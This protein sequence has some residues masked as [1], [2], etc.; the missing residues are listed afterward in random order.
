MAWQT[1]DRL[2]GF[3]ALGRFD[4][5]RDVYEHLAD[6]DPAWPD[7]KLRL[8]QA[9]EKALD[10]LETS[11]LHRPWLTGRRCPSG[12]QN[13]RSIPRAG[14]MGRGAMGAVYL[15]NPQTGAG[16]LKTMAL[17]QEFE[18]DG[19]AGRGLASSAKRK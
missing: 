3:E 14:E 18:G 8:T 16:S 1:M 5:A 13:H 12:Q 6:V 4:L 7:I 17:S 11:W 19:L 2:G 15:E 10:L 9:R